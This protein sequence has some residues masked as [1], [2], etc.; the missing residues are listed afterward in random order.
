[1]RGP[2]LLLAALVPLTAAAATA[3]R[4]AAPAPAPAAAGPRV[5]F[6][7]LCLERCGDGPA[8]ISAQVAQLA[9]RASLF[10]GAAFEEF[11]L[12]PNATL[13]KNNLT[14]V[15]AALAAAG[16][17]QR[18]AMISSYP[19]PP[20]FLSYMRALFAAP[21]PFIAAALD[22]LAADPAL[23]GFNVD[24]E[25]VSGGGAPTP[26]AADAAAYAGFLDTFAR[27]LHAA[28]RGYQLT[29][30]VAT[31]SPIWNLTAIGATAV[32]G[33]AHMGTYVGNFT[34]W[35]AQLAQLLDAVPLAK[36]VVGLETTNDD[37]GGRPFTPAE[38]AARFG[39]LAAAGVRAVGVWR[40]PIP[41]A[42]WPFLE[43]L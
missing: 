40:A 30:A 37:A 2:L 4:A 33:V 31:W 26:T 19:Y 25:P 10:T 11:N 23:T 16:L 12:G 27:A 7:W 39:A 38:L 22:A 20:Q 43:A 41:D 28:G 6:P 1:M 13:V 18:H 8:N 24:W 5:L 14:A 9:A 29:V 34:T 32:D 3:L 35:S 42:W 15:S 21:G 17:R 36:A